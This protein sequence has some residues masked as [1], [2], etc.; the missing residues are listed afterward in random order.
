MS[1]H[2][3]TV[4]I[5]RT[6]RFVTDDSSVAKADGDSSGLLLSSSMRI[7]KAIRCINLTMSD[8]NAKRI[9]AVFSWCLLYRQFSLTSD[10]KVYHVFFILGRN[11]HASYLLCVGLL[12][13]CGV[14]PSLIS[15]ALICCFQLSVGIPANKIEYQYLP[16]CTRRVI[17]ARLTK[18]SMNAINYTSKTLILMTVPLPFY[19]PCYCPISRIAL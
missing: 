11:R 2:A 14:R 9:K 3:I 13:F 7:G 18:C 10:F 15:K 1:A 16:D 5:P 6:N 17:P 19:N 8:D 12:F 4:L